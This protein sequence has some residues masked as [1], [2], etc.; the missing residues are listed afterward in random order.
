MRHQ[1]RLPILIAA[2][3]LAATSFANLVTN[4]D[5]SLWDDPNQPSGWTVE[6]TTKTKVEQ[7][8]DP[9]RSPLYSA[10]ETRLID[11]LGNN[12]G[13]SQLVSVTPNA[14]YALTARCFDEDPLVKGG[15]S[16]TW[17]KAD[18]TTYIS[19][20]GVTYSDSG[21]TGWQ[22]LAMTDSSPAE[23]GLAEVLLRVYNLSGGTPAGGK[24]YFDDVEF[25]T[26]MGAIVEQRSGRAVTAVDMELRPN[27]TTGQSMV[28]FGLARAAHVELNVYDLT[29]SSV[30]EL[31]AGP[32]NAG[33]HRFPFAG[34]N[35]EGALLPAGLYFLVLTDGGNH[36]TVRKVVFEP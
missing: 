23:A 11:S 29:G 16:I 31:Y 36:S 2:L 1:L 15:I 21:L 17:R 14:A 13:L 33:Q 6:D 35:R 34:R 8:S 19:T 10:R 22:K 18:T 9:V 4:A 26:G 3:A 5:F 20:S 7:S 28:S 30:A 12:K 32:L 27:P 25:D 24:V